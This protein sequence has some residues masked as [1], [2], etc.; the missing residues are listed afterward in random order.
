MSKPAAALAKQVIDHHVKPTP[1]GAGAGRTVKR[2]PSNT[3]PPQQQ[4]LRF[5]YESHPKPINCTTFAT[6]KDVA[7]D[8]SHPFYIRT[9][10]RLRAFNTGKLHWRVQCSVDVSKRGFVRSWAVK[11]VQGAI[12]R[13]LGTQEGKREESDGAGDDAGQESTSVRGPTVDVA[14]GEGDHA[15]PNA[16]G[17]SGALLIFLPKDSKLALTATKA[18][19]E[20]SAEWVLKEV[21]RLQAEARRKGSHRPRSGR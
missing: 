11:R 7:N 6:T 15:R 18:Q 14:R 2:P 9:Q 3:P 8:P 12:A 5:Q 20:E 10:R 21:T 19:V 13:R 16:L 4:Y 1:I 17:L